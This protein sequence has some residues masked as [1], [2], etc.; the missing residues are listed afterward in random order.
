MSALIEEFK[1]EHS[2]IIAI[3]KEVKKLGIHSEEGRAKLMS[4]KEYLL[5]HLHKENEQLYPVLRKSAEHNKTLKNELDIFAMDPAYVSR[6]VLEFFDKY[7]GGVTDKDF[8]INFESLVAS[9]N[10]R[11]R[12]EEEALYQEYEEIKKK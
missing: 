3:L 12:N 1:K 6:V 7:S 8:K 9:L 4:A 10:A 5:E 2:E 11:I